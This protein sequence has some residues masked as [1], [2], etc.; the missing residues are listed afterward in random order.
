MPMIRRSDL[1]ADQQAHPP[2]GT[3]GFAA[4]EPPVRVGTTGGADTLLLLGWTASQLAAEVAAGARLFESLGIRAGMRVANTLP[5]AL[6][7]PGALLTGDVNEALGALDIPLGV[8]DTEAAAKPAWELFDRV[9]VNVLIV[10]PGPATT[11]FFAAA[12]PVD[13]PWWTGI[14]WLSRGGVAA[15]IPAPPGFAGWQRT[16]LAIPEVSSFVA[17]SCAA[18]S[19]H[20]RADLPAAVTDGELV[21]DAR[22]YAPGLRARHLPACACGGTGIAFAP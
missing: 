12:P 19:F 15:P 13:R 7:T 2:W 9:Q 11:T 6:V 5:G 1:V 16:W 17:T 21:L 10:E 3:P 20:V 14:V 18:G 8:V 4:D 22:G